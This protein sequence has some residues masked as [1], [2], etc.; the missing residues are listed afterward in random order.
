M[1]RFHG[2]QLGPEERFASEGKD[3]RSLL[4]DEGPAWHVVLPTFGQIVQW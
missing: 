2:W 3:A 1:Y 4:R